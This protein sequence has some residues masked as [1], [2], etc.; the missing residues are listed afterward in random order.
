MEPTDPLWA[1][2]KC[3]VARQPRRAQPLSRVAFPEAELPCFPVLWKPV[4]LTRFDLSLTV[5]EQ[6]GL[7]TSLRLGF[8]PCK[9]EI[10]KKTSTV[11]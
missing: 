5:L 2:H 9:M 6:V 4:T 8:F 1:E 3:T 10:K 11:F 7:L